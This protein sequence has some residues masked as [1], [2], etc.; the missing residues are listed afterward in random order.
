MAAADATGEALW[1]AVSSNLVYESPSYPFISPGLLGKSDG[2]IT[3]RDGTGAILS[4][5]VAFVLI[6]PGPALAGWL[7]DSGRLWI[8]KPLVHAFARPVGLRELLQP[9]PRFAR[10]APPRLDGRP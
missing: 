5:R 7:A 8:R 3:V 10:S 4:S 9:I 1:Y 2:W 6:A